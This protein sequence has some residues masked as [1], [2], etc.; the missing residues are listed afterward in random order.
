MFS[1]LSHCII[2]ALSHYSFTHSLIQNSLIITRH[3]LHQ[4]SE[5]YLSKLLNIIVFDWLMENND[6]INIFEK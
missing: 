2:D 5:L 3:I 1:S 4:L 6:L